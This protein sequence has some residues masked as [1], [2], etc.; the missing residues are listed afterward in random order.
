MLL[1]TDVLIAAYRN[2]YAPDLCQGFWD[3][4]SHHFA[5][6][7]LVMIDRVRREI[8]S[9]NK[10]V[11]WVDEIPQHAHVAT[12]ASPVSDAYRRVMN[13]VVSSQQFTDAAKYK[14]ARDADPWLIAYAM[15]HNVD[16]ITNE[17]YDPN[18][19][20]AVKIPNVCRNFGVSYGD[21]Y[22]MLRSLGAK[23]T[24]KRP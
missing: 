12:S 4:V 8:Q 2:Y 17:V 11:K 16:V 24:W 6:G 21:T 14:F 22:G 3:F 1:D 7:Q 9:P 15:V 13:W 10:L 5:G 20:R 23:F 18:V 19:R